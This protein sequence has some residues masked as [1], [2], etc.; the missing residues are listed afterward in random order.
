MPRIRQIC[1]DFGKYCYVLNPYRPSRQRLNQFVIL[2]I[3]WLSLAVRLVYLAYIN[4]PAQDGLLFAPL[5]GIDA[6]IYDQYSQGALGGVWP[7][8]QPLE[9]PPLYTLYLIFS[10]RLFGV[11]HY[12]PLIVQALG[13]SVAVAALYSVGR[14]I[15]SKKAGQLAALGFVL[16]DSMIFY[17][18]CFAQVSLVAPLI[19]L[20]LFFLLKSKELN[21]PYYLIFA[22]LTLGMAALGRPNLL[23]L[24][25]A[26]VGW[27]WLQRQNWRQW[28]GLTA[29]FA[30]A[31]WLTIAPLTL[32]NYQASGNFILIS[33]NGPVNLFISHNAD[34]EGRD[35]LAPGIVQPVHRRM[36]MVS[37]AIERDETTFT[38]EVVNYIRQEPL[39][40][41]LLEIN[42]LWLLL[43]ESDLNIMTVA[44]A[45]LTT[46]RQIA[47]FE[48][49]PIQWHGLVISAFLGMVLI[50]RKYTSLLLL[51]F[52][53][54][55]LATIIFFVQ[56]R[57]R[58]LLAP[59]VLLYAAALLAE[60]PA[61]FRSERYKFNFTLL[62][63]LLFIPFTPGVWLFGLAVIGIGIWQAIKLNVWQQTRWL[64]LTGW[65]LFV[66]AV[67][68]SQIIISVNRIGQ[69]EGYYLGTEII[70]DIFLGQTFQPDCDGLNR[71]RLTL[72]IHNKTHNQPVTFYLHSQT[73]GR[74][75]FTDQ[76][77]TQNLTDRTIKEFTFS[78]QPDSSRQTYLAYLISPTSHPGNN[79]TLRGFSSLPVDWYPDG[80]AIVGQGE[81]IQP[82]PGDLA[83]TAF[84]DTDLVGTVDTAFAR[85][86]GSK[87]LYWS[88]LGGHI[89]LFTVA[90]A[91]IS[92]GLI[93]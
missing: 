48:I 83:F 24:L 26:V 59:V 86:P 63:L 62:I 25:P 11:N 46:D 7:N 43:G 89:V 78:P 52:A 84:C 32:Y 49:M 47:I 29:Y 19:I 53:F 82:F 51:F 73:T 23:L 31:V 35:I 42:K 90:L 4:E 56:L 64:L 69:Q 50:R 34:T 54:I 39:D 93:F 76:F 77:T 85:L 79:I 65:S 88:V 12:T 75:I 6:H 16:Y 55:T 22:G 72:G 91:Q 3:V 21:R 36:E 10:Y 2:G 38:R 1:H 37:A 15:F 60:T 70:G 81:Q 17:T 66:L 74:D 28:L 45:Y 9:R 67:L 14:F 30:G 18:G 61:W 40:W 33:T 13:Q 44:F 57:F 80:T 27:L 5:C 68:V 92:R 71:I 87:W 8:N 20:T 58:L 41:L